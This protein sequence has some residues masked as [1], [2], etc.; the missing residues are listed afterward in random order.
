ME[1]CPLL[2]PANYQYGQS[3]YDYWDDE[4]TS[5]AREAPI[6]PESCRPWSPCPGSSC[7]RRPR[8]SG[9]VCRT[10]PGTGHPELGNES[11]E[12]HFLSQPS[13]HRNSRSAKL[14]YRASGL[15]RISVDLMVTCIMSS[16]SLGD[17]DSPQISSPWARDSSNCSPMEARS[18][19]FHTL[20]VSCFLHF[21]RQVPPLQ[22]CGS[23]HSG[24]R[25]SR[26]RW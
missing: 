16:L 3:M 7:P 25:S 15:G 6:W 10:R 19:S 8:V 9:E 18:S 26:M 5:A 11:S 22:M 23:S 14:L 20:T 17:T 1:Y 21:I 12:E 24:G 2:Q 13:L 4:G